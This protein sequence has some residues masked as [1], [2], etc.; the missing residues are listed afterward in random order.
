MHAP[1]AIKSL[2]TIGVAIALG[3]V[4]TRV[5]DTTLTQAVSA[6]WP[7]APGYVR[8]S[9]VVPSNA[10]PFIDELSL[11]YTYQ[12]GTEWF[13]S[14]RLTFFGDGLSQ[15]LIGSA[16]D[17]YDAYPEGTAIEIAYDPTNPERAV[18]R[19]GVTTLE[20]SGAGLLVVGLGGV[21][22]GMFVHGGTR[23]LAQV[24][25]GEAAREGRRVVTPRAG[26]VQRARAA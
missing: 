5:A 23:L 10:N 12:I 17:M 2:I 4:A 6:D 3:V 19:T 20:L 15:L 26:A 13:V 18:L 24:K 8:T 25:S 22:L 11:E 21:A 16:Q 7:K 9:E 1:T 14:D